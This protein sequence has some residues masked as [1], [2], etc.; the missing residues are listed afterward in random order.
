V[1]PVFGAQVVGQS[2]LDVPCPDYGFEARKRMA[3]AAMLDRLQRFAEEAKA[4][5]REPMVQGDHRRWAR[6][7]IA[8][9]IAV[10][11]VDILPLEYACRALN[12]AAAEVMAERD[13]R[14]KLF[15]EKAA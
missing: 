6:E 10:G 13:D 8:K 7:L 14:N 5:W 2:R 9:Y 3:E 1:D 15:K 4:P 11:K 12:R